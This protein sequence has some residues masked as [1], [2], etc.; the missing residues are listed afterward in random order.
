MENSHGCGVRK[1]EGPEGGEYVYKR[2]IG[3]IPVMELF[4]I[5][6][7]VVDIQ[8]HRNDKIV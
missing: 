4:C 7:M 5:L 3:G 2:A 6:S 8:T 1:R